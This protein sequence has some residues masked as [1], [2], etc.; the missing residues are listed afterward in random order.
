MDMDEM[1]PQIVRV[2]ACVCPVRCSS[3]VFETD[4]HARTRTHTLRLSWF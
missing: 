1:H 4:T 2:C 3:V